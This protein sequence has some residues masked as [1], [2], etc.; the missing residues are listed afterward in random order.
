MKIAFPPVIETSC[1]KIKA[2]NTETIIVKITKNSAMIEYLFIALRFSVNSE[3]RKLPKKD[4]PEKSKNC[5]KPNFP[6]TKA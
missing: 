1:H 5:K 2:K 4:T 3:V 6:K